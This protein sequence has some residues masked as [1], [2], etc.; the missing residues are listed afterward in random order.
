M[1]LLEK[2]SIYTGFLLEKIKSEEEAMKENE[3][4]IK[5]KR[6]S[7]GS[8]QTSSQDKST[9]SKGRS[10]KRK[11]PAVSDVIDKQVPVI[12][13]HSKQ[14]PVITNTV[15]SKRVHVSLITYHSKQ[16]PVI[17]NPSKQV[18]VPLI[19]YHSKQVPVII[20]F[21]INFLVRLCL[22]TIYHGT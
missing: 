4:K 22:I 15:F 11:K 21:N 5:I 2:S 17:T 18:H 14:V 13:N 20:S 8:S 16:V 19:T 12:T 3:E 10:S 9:G 6:I 7:Q 1:H